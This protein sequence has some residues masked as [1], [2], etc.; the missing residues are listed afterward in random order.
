MWDTR[1]PLSSIILD[2]DIYPSP[3][4]R[5]DRV[6]SDDKR[7][8]DLC[9]KA[10]KKAVACFDIEKVAGQYAELYGGIID[11]KKIQPQINVDG[12]RWKTVWSKE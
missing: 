5:I 3:L 1:I 4:T 10:R 12:R 6:L 2:E 7:Y 11:W 9:I 8:K